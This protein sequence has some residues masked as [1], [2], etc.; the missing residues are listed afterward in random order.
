MKILINAYNLRIG[1]GESVGVGI[2][3]AIYTLNTTN[4]YFILVNKKASYAKFTST[5]N[6]VVKHA[7]DFFTHHLLGNILSIFY[8]IYTSY[9]L[10]PDAIFSMGNYAIP[11]KKKQLLF[12]HWPYLVY[13]NSV[14]WEI[15]KWSS[16][17]MKRKIRAWIMKKQLRFATA[18]TVQTSLMKNQFEKYFSTPHHIHVVESAAS[19]LDNTFADNSSLA[20]KIDALKA[21]YKDY[22][23]LLCLSKYYTHKNLEVLIPLAE[24]IKNKNTQFK[25][26]IN[27]D[28]T[29]HPKAAALLDLIQQK[30]LGDVIF[31]LGIVSQQD[32][33][34]VYK[35][36][37]GFI[38]PTL[39]ES[40]G[41]I[42]REAMILGIPIFTS[43]LDFAHNACGNA[44]FYFDPLDYKS[45]YDTITNAYA[46]PMLIQNKIDA[47]KKQA[48][49]F[50][51]WKEIT[52][53]YIEIIEQL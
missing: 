26:L 10:N 16:D 46:D 36:A 39:L 33:A 42:Y 25:I 28:A 12:L 45:I 47:G 51:S 53:K 50:L 31:N 5:E 35:Q 22:T 41:I 6:I 20:I 17:Y 52:R 7:P 2:I 29:Q 13:P 38:L 15:S 44:A 49:D 30:K 11:V 9:R 23:F 1:G 19:E 21:T 40:F 27:L 48:P 8:L 34:M 32:L 3:E 37:D 18:V 24:N 43:D 4:Q 14:A